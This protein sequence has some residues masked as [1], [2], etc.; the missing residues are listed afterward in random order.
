MR[1]NADKIAAALE[2]YVNNGYNAPKAAKDTGVTYARLTWWI[3]QHYF[4]KMHGHTI[5]LQSKC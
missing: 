4:K 5:T 3:T 2:A 1:K